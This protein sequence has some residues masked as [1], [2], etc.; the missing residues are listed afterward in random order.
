MRSDVTRFLP[1]P[2]RC[3]ETFGAWRPAVDSEAV[4]E[5]GSF[6]V[7]VESAAGGA[8][9][10]RVRGELDLATAPALEEA[11]GTVDPA[12][13]LVVDLR[14]CTFVDSTSVRVL[15][16]LARDR[17]TNGSR[18]AIVA[19]DPGVLRVLDITALDTIVAVHDTLE[20]ALAHLG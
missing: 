5:G 8:S 17:E 1:A 13:A 20:D 16:N 2:R 10:V 7:V 15:G 18:A 19:T 11:V 6:E 3:F 9:V 14:Q 12:S 4:S